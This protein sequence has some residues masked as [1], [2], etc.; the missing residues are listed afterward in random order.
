MTSPSDFNSQLSDLTI[1]L[2]GMVAERL[3]WWSREMEPGER[4]RILDM[5]EGQLPGI[6]ANSIAKSP[7]LHSAAGVAYLEES[8]EEYA[9]AYAKKFIGKI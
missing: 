3:A 1:K 5:I 9:D 6:I 4:R 2:S 8:L 7:S